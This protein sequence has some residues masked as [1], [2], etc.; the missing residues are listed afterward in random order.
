M[1]N[2]SRNDQHNTTLD[3]RLAEFT[4]EALE[5][6]IS[7][8]ASPVDEDL[9]LLEKT[10]LRLRDA[11]PPTSLDTARVKQMQVRLKNRIRREAREESQPFWRTWLTRPQ[12][13]AVMGILGMVLVFIALSPYLSAPGSSTAATALTPARGGILALGVAFILALV[14]WF[15]RRK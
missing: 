3:D 4:D 11:Y 14:L 6:R 12:T 1:N 9:L 10:I 15:R 13:W 5:G 7:S 2:M 8:P